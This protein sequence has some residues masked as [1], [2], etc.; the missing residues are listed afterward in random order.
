[1][2]DNVPSSVWLPDDPGP[3]PGKCDTCNNRGW[4]DQTLGGRTH[5]GWAECPDCCNP[6]REPMP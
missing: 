3:E 2:S 4:I 1:V 6:Y 5:S